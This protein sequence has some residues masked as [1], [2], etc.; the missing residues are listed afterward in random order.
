MINVAGDYIMKIFGALRPH[1]GAKT[2]GKKEVERKKR[3][4]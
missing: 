2:K 3:N 4:K 1:L